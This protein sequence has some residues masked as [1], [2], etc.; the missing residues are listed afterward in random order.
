MTGG[1]PPVVFF[2]QPNKKTI[3]K[4]MF[5]D[6]LYVLHEL[7][8]VHHCHAPQVLHFLPTST[9]SFWTSYSAG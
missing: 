7:A 8:C 4:L 3:R 6:G 9:F 2:R 1:I 5:P